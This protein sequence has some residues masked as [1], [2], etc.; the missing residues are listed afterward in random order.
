MG[1]KGFFDSNFFGD[2]VHKTHAEINEKG[3]FADVGTS[4][5]DNSDEG[6][7]GTICDI[8]PGVKVSKFHCD[9]PFVF[10]ICDRVSQEVLFAGLYRGPE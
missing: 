7:R 10:T 2:I 1:L 3:L 8:D 9:R 5:A 6:S 4:T